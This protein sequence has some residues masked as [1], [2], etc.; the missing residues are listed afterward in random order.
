MIGATI[1]Y[2]RCMPKHKLLLVE[3]QPELGEQTR[4]W[5]ELND[6]AV[7][8]AQSGRQALERLSRAVYDLIVLDLHLGDIDGS[9]V[10]AE[11]RKMGG[12]ARIL[13]LTGRDSAADKEMCLDIG[14]DDY[15][16]KPAEPK[17]MAARLRALMRRSLSLSARLLKVGPVQIDLDA[18]KVSIQGSE[19]AL[20]PQ[21]YALLEF[22]ARHPNRIFAAEVLID[23][24][25][26]GN[27][28]P[29]TVRTCIKTLRKKLENAGYDKIIKT[30]HGMGY[31]LE[32]L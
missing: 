7:D 19:I 28:S 2:N 23:R 14:A 24:L 6:Y 32:N 3:D 22:L 27:A 8:W 15:L 17:E 1:I 9:Q 5:L 30:V 16:I 10:C 18:A 11:Y 31:C 12:T 13:I 26:R 21:E 20:Q 25:W 4:D 29:D